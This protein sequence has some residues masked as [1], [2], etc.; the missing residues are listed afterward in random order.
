MNQDRMDQSQKN[1]GRID[2]PA[3]E[4][5]R[6][7]AEHAILA[8]K[9]KLCNQ[10]ARELMEKEVRGQGVFAAEIYEQKQQS[11]VLATRMQHLR[12]RINRIK[13]GLGTI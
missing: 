5:K 7:E 9:Q 12:A 6:L 1:P 2:D 3:A 13:L 11:I 8:E 10:A 4:I